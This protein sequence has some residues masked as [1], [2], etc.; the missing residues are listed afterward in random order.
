[1]FIKRET[2]VVTTDSHGD[3]TTYTAEV[4]NG[5]IISIQYVE[6]SASSYDTGFDI[7][8]TSAITEQNI[9]SQDSLGDSASVTVAPRQATQTTA[10]VAITYDDDPVHDYIALANERIKI[11]VDDGG[12][13]KTGTF[14]ITIG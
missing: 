8:I 2:V 9:W 1:M 7:A 3:N 4:I 12:D 13:T 5:R 14:Y 10:G 11:V 6:A